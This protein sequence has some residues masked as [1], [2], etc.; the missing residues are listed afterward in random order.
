MTT[1]ELD[2]E[3]EAFSHFYIG[4]YPVRPMPPIV[5]LGPLASFSDTDAA[6]QQIVESLRRSG[7][8]LDVWLAPGP[9]GLEIM[10]RAMPTD[11]VQ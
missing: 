10:C 9:I 1:E 8:W 5:S 3:M 2:D 4:G 7:C 6:P 11:P